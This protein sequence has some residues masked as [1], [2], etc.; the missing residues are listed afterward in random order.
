MNS[1]NEIGFNENFGES[2]IEYF[3]ERR[4]GSEFRV[5]SDFNLTSEDRTEQIVKD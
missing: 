1:Q 3:D 5:R 2:S 4:G